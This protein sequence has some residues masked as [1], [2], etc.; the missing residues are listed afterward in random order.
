MSSRLLHIVLPGVAN[1][2]LQLAIHRVHD[3][4]RHSQNQGPR[5]HLHVLGEDGTRTDDRPGP[6]ADPIEEDRAHPD[7][8]L[9]LHVATVEDCAMPD[10]NPV[11]DRARHAFIDVQ[12]RE[13][14]DVRGRADRNR[15]HVA[16]HDRVVPD[17]GVGSDGDVAKDDRARRDERRRV[18]QRARQGSFNQALT[19]RPSFCAGV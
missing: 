12:H 8:A 10:S 15:G 17:R 6:D 11:P 5:R 13:V 19:A 18:D 16:A 4:T 1:A 2:S 14:L 3:S 7:E 9:V